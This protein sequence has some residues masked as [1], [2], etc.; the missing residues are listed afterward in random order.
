MRNIF[1]FFSFFI[2]G[3]SKYME[4]YK[5]NSEYNYHIFLPKNWMEYETD[6]K[7]TNAFFDTLSWTANLR[8]TPFNNEIKN[9]DNFFAEE[10]AKEDVVKLKWQ[11]FGGIKY[12][13]KSSEETTYFWELI[14]NKRLYICSFTIGNL[15]EV[16]LIQEIEKVEKVLKSI[17]NKYVRH[18]ITAGKLIT[19]VF[20]KL[21]LQFHE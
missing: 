21:N 7:N 16:E 14:K 20:G 11:D 6:E 12:I 17:I 8:V 4:T 10:L 13:E 1:T 3:Y 18:P 2:I 5:F 9:V 19:L 15:L